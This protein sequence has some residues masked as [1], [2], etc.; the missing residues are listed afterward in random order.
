MAGSLTT[1]WP[2]ST[3]SRLDAGQVEGHPLAAGRRGDLAVVHLDAPHAHV[4]AAPP[5]PPAR[6]A[7][8]GRMATVSSAAETARPERARDH[9]PIP[10]R[11]KT[12]S[13]GMRVAG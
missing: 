11:E 7:T 5:P 8:G 12:L 2:R 9:R 13:T 6:P 3:S 4:A 10:F 1:H